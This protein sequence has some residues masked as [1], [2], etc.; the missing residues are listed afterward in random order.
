M[1]LTVTLNGIYKHYH[2]EL[3]PRL[4]LPCTKSSHWG[5]HFNLYHPKHNCSSHPF[6]YNFNIV[7]ALVCMYY[8]FY[9]VD[10]KRDEPDGQ[11]ILN[12]GQQQ[13]G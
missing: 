11:G 5:G 4:I 10:D 13:N 9:A 6:S 8:Y 7:V 12:N 1:C 3:L 2:S